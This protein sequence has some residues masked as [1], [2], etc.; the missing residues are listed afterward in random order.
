MGACCCCCSR[1]DGYNEESTRCICARCCCPSCIACCCGG[2]TIRRIPRYLQN[3]STIFI[4]HVSS[5]GWKGVIT[6]L[7]VT[8]KERTQGLQVQDC[9]NSSKR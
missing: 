1:E 5:S 3:V 4:L 2:D 8:S 7:Y 9:P 6:A